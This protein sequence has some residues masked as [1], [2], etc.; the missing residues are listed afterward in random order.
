MKS[1][2]LVVLSIG[3][4]LLATSQDITG[5]WQGI[6][7]V[8][9]NNIRLLF[10]ITATNGKYTSTF[11]SPDQHAFGLTCSSTEVIN[12]S[13]L[14]GI[15]IVQGG[16]RGKWNGK[17]E[18]TG[19][20]FQAGHSIPMLL[21]RLDVKEIGKMPDT[22][23]KP[24]TPKPPFS[25]LS[26]D[27]VYTNTQQNIQLAATLTR[28]AGDKKVPVVIMIT[29]SGPQDRDETIGQHKPFFVIA[30]YLAK[31]GIAV[32]RVDDRGMGKST[33][34]F[35]ASSSADFATDVV[36]GINYLKTRKDIDV[37][38]IGL[39]GHSEGG[40]IAPYVAARNKDVAFI[41]TL[42]GPAVG[43]Q[44]IN[45]FQNT[46]PMLQ[47]G[48][49][50]KEV[51]AFLVLHHQLVNAAI[52]ILPDSTYKA[53]VTNIYTGWQK[54]QTKTT[55]HALVKVVDSNM[56]GKMQKNYAAF[57][58]PWWKFFLAYDPATDLQKMRIPVLALNGEKDAQVEA[59]SNLAAFTKA[60]Q[61][62]SSKNFKT[63]EVPGVNHLFQHCKKCG[64][65]DEYFALEETFDPATLVIIGDWIKSVVK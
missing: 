47:S 53:A 33:G 65:L 46:L 10:H 52:T 60:L 14:L 12:D 11:D 57:R 32:L 54:I 1:F 19:I 56:L 21:K 39:I 63:I 23:P 22:S 49:S 30:D 38:K 59:R 29:G 58:T 3:I 31:Q 25:Y 45:D 51:D 7:S 6:L 28:P 62:S 44:K 24:Q 18:I 16:Y 20:Y 35:T 41:V 4:G 34:N 40:L 17:D 9:G 5:N 50:K 55:L 2:F 15:Q 13:I 36:A 37:T 64:S 43:G 48:I 26:E 27:V 61:K 42:A 8:N